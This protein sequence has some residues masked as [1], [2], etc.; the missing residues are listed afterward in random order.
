M[1][2]PRGYLT[3][4]LL[5]ACSFVVIV[6]AASEVVA[7]SLASRELHQFYPPSFFLLAANVMSSKPLAFKQTTTHVA[8]P[9]QSIKNKKERSKC[10]RMRVFIMALQ[11]SAVSRCVRI[12]ATA[13]WRLLNPEYYEECLWAYLCQLMSFCCQKFTQELESLHVFHAGIVIHC[14]LPCSSFPVWPAAVKV[15]LLDDIARTFFCDMVLMPWEKSHVSNWCHSN[16]WWIM[17]CLNLKLF[18]QMTTALITSHGSRVAR[19]IRSSYPAWKG[20]VKSG[21]RKQAIFE[22]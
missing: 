16:K 22:I 11:S 6:S 20:L 3:T 18:H 10:L 4:L 9:E 15:W 5:T 14:W 8:L 19:T 17:Q 13:E 1:K 2:Q 21:S 7:F 12:K